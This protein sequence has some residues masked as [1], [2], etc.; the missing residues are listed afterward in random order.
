MLLNDLT[1]IRCL[2]L[3]CLTIALPMQGA[4]LSQAQT[5]KMRVGTLTCKGKG[6]IGWIIGSKEKLACTFELSRQGP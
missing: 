3:T 6:R 4:S 5:A 1:I 2:L